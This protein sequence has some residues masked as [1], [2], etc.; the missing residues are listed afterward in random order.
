GL[1]VDGGA[2]PPPGRLDREPRAAALL[3]AGAEQS[4]RHVD[5]QA[6]LVEARALAERERPE[7][8]RVVRYEHEAC[9]ERCAVQADP[10]RAAVR[11]HRGERAQA[12]E[13]HPA[14]AVSLAPV[15]EPRVEAERDVVQ[16]E[17]VAGAADVD[18]P[19]APVRERVE[20]RD[21][22]VAVEA[23]VAGEV[24]PGAEG[25]AHEREVALERDARHDRE[26]A[27]AS[28]HPESVAVGRARERLDV[29][30]LREDVRLD[31]ALRRRREQLLGAAVA[32]MR[33]HDQ[34]S[35]HGGAYTWAFRM[36]KMGR[37]AHAA[38]R[39]G[40]DHCAMDVRG[41][42]HLIEDDLADSWVEDWARGGVEA[43][44]GYLQKHLA[45]LSYL[46]ES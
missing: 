10:Q 46:D 31:P 26:R 44:E 37:T 33:V 28:R 15:H 45:F 14:P 39:A 41:T 36:T 22:V 17:S 25:D 40:A 9:T 7:L 13:C 21:G 42:L 19:L 1:A 5:V 4:L 27:V 29:V 43:V 16:E 24:V 23:D 32:R 6:P 12:G 11:R 34:E 20:R 38:V 35:G 18:A 30:V 8:V 3:P 2:Q